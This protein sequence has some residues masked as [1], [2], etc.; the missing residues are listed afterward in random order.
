MIESPV[1]LLA[2]SAEHGL[3]PRHVH[4]TFSSPQGAR[5][6]PIGFRHPAEPREAAAKSGLLMHSLSKQNKTVIFPKIICHIFFINLLVY[7]HSAAI[8]HQKFK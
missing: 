7:C 4:W 8:S 2:C 1:D 6:R 5:L 3:L